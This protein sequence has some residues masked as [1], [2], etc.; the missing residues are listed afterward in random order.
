MVPTVSPRLPPPRRPVSTPDAEDS[1]DEVSLHPSESDALLKES[2]EVTGGKDSTRKHSN[3]D[4]DSS[5]PQDED[6]EEQDFDTSAKFSFEK[7]TN[8]VFRYLPEEV[9]PRVPIPKTNRFL[10]FL[11]IGENEETEESQNVLPMAS[12]ISSLANTLDE[13][14]CKR[15]D[16][17]PWAPPNAILTKGF[18]FHPGNYKFSREPFPIANPPLDADASRLGI[19]PPQS[20]SSSLK[21]IERWE[22]RSRQ[23]VGVASYSNAFTAALHAALKNPDEI[24]GP[25]IKL[26][27]DALN[28]ATNHTVG[29]S[30]ALASELFKVRR[31][32]H[33]PSGPSLS[34]NS[35]RRI[36]AAPISATTLLNGLVPEVAEAERNDRLRD[37]ATSSAKGP[38][39][40]FKR[41]FPKKGG[42]GR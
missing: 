34:E 3:T 22:S 30:M 16:T 7:A 27:L 17:V 36:R 41:P 21:Q 25:S 28:K 8:E 23:L 40:T 33:I 13:D 14:V 38:K 4:H 9:C 12:A 11:D 42:G 10:G 19:R 39:N 5:I 35:K 1:P 29:L 6:L 37:A 18:K 20:I 26:L 15:A 24:D 32:G 2:R 31:E